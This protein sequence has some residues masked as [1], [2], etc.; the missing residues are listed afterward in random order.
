[1]TNRTTVHD[2]FRIER[3]FDAVPQKVFNAFADP[4]AKA[5]WFGGPAEMKREDE[6]FDFRE[7]GRETQVSVF[8][9]GTRFGFFATYT[10]IV[11]GERIVYTYEMSMNGER[12]SVSVVTVEVAAGASGGTDFVVTEQG[13]YLDGLDTPAQRRQGTEDLLDA[14]AKSL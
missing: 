12:I 3:H 7:G 6:S 5:K 10:D 2:T 8:E 13:V 1:M 14:L 9:N 4:A 11:P